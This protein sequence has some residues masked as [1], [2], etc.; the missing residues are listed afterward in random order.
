MNWV[1]RTIDTLLPLVMLYSLH[2][3]LVDTGWKEVYSW[4]GLVSGLLLQLSVHLMGGYEQYAQKT[5]ARK[6]EMVFKSWVVILLVCLLI[7]YLWGD[8]ELVSRRLFLVWA[9]ITPIV[10]I[11]IKLQ[12]NASELFSDKKLQKGLIVGAAYEFS[13]LETEQLNLQKVDIG[14]FNSEK[15][16]ELRQTVEVEN[17]QFVILNVRKTVSN[18]LVKA[19]TRAEL[20]GVRMMTMNHFF[21]HYLQK[22]FIAYDSEGVDYLDSVHGYYPVQY[23]F[24]RG[25][26]YL[27]GG[28]L[29]FVSLPIFGYVYLKVKKESPGTIFFRQHRI[30]LNGKSFEV[31]K[32]RTMHENAHFDPYTKKEDS[33]IFPFGKFMRKSRIDELPQLWNVLKGDMH[34]FGP[35]T[36]WCILVENYEKEIPYYHERH[37]VRPGISGWAQV[38]YPYGANTEDSRQ[39]LMY[40]LYYIS[41]WSVWLEI[42]T[43]IRTIGVVMGRKG[44]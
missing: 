44:L 13:A 17:I 14:V 15:L 34:L 2:F 40:D 42:E 19:L 12:L 8:I 30:G 33:R 1:F 4:L 38:M 3:F 29:L 11:Y 32:F 23:V 39:K 25:I 20:T 36:E 43:I 24:K 27:V 37:L 21:E 6:L 26:D 7:A 31:V 22:S 5:L 41:H 28:A 18:E 9:L 16:D 10:I 35:R